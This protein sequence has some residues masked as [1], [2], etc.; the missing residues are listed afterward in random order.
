MCTKDIGMIGPVV[1]QISCIQMH[2]RTHAHTHVY[3]QT[4]GLHL[5]QITLLFY[6]ILGVLLI[7][8]FSKIL[9]TQTR[10]KF[11]KFS[12][13]AVGFKSQVYRTHSEN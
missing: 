11:V 7:H 5:A 4:L 2:T 10:E 12:V 8:I 6:E 13:F 9:F 3:N 1:C